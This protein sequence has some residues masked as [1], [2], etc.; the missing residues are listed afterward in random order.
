[1]DLKKAQ[2]SMFIILGLVILLAFTFIYFTV[3]KYQTI[4]TGGANSELVNMEMV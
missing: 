4:E 1:M 3:N 2:I